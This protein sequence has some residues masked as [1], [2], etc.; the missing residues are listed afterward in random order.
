MKSLNSFSQIV[1]SEDGK[2]GRPDPET[3]EWN[4]MIGMVEKGKGDL[5]AADLTTTIARQDVLDFSRSFMSSPLTVLTKVGWA[6][7][8][9]EERRKELE[10]NHL[11]SDKVHRLRRR[12]DVKSGGLFVSCIRCDG[13][14]LHAR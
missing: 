7:G 10:I 3:G 5:I 6:L 9:R 1:L 8:G 13:I 14:L 12:K 4:G 11:P 2:Y